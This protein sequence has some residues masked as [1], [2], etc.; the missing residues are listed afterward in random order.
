M[1]VAC[2]I[3]GC[4]ADCREDVRKYLMQTPKNWSE[5]YKHTKEMPEISSVVN[6]VR[7]LI[8][9]GNDIV[10]VTGR[11][12][13]TR[14]DTKDWLFDTVLV[15]PFRPPELLMRQDKD[16]RPS[17]E[18]KLKTFSE[19][20]PDL[21]IEDEPEVVKRATE[22]GFTVLQVHGYRI[23]EKDGIPYV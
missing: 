22:V 10:F 11:P 17:W 1:I 7:S 21:I 14:E 3:D 16:H 9:D 12:E 19:L 4:L 5:Y 20:K 15:Y 13:S 2:D 23:T 6:L 8:K 18:L